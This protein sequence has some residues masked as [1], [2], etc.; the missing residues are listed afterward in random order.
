MKKYGLRVLV[1]LIAF[2]IGVSAVILNVNQP[3]FCPIVTKENEQTEPPLFS[4]QTKPKL[5]IKVYFKEFK[6][7]KDGI[8]AVVKVKNNSVF[9]TNYKVLEGIESPNPHFMFNEVVKEKSGLICGYSN[10]S[11][12]Q[13]NSSKSVEFKIFV[14]YFEEYFDNNG[15]LK[16]GYLF[17]TN[18]EKQIYWSEDIQIPDWVKDELRKEK[19]EN[20]KKWRDFNSSLILHPSSLP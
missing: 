17:Y 10:I 3:E 5:K 12:R 15:S 19:L 4:D 1:G 6:K 2:A 20:A 9:S 11:S 8:F 16:I 13:L 14:N 7:T 18:G